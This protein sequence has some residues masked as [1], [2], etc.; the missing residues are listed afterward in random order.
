[1]LVDVGGGIGAQSILVAEAH[2]H[3]HV[4][5]EDREQVVST[6]KS[7]RVALFL[8]ERVI[9]DDFGRLGDHDTPNCSIQDVCRGAHA[10]SS[11]HGHH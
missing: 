3:I 5:V 1:M 8:S 2:P 7:V 9:S 6:A 4:V 10:I 11:G